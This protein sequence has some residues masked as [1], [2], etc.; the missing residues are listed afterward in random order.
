M[1]KECGLTSHTCNPLV[2]RIWRCG[3]SCGSPASGGHLCLHPCHV[4]APLLPLDPIASPCCLF[5]IIIK[6]MGC[7]ENTSEDGAG[8]QQMNLELLCPAAERNSGQAF[9]VPWSVHPWDGNLRNK[10]PRPLWVTVETG[11]RLGLH[12]RDRVDLGYVSVILRRESETQRAWLGAREGQNH[13]C[14]GRQV[15]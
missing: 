8:H 4:A 3:L 5:R 9:H 7:F 2:T 12:A 13:I 1:R 11:P 10:S 6:C 15:G 14:E